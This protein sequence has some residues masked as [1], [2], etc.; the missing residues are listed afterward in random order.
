MTAF[1]QQEST[2]CQL[3]HKEHTEN[4][5]YDEADPES[6]CAYISSCPDCALEQEKSTEP[7]KTAVDFSDY[8][9][10][11]MPIIFQS[12][13]DIDLHD[14]FVGCGVDESITFTCSPE[15]VSFSDYSDGDLFNITLTATGDYEGSFDLEGEV[16]L[17]NSKINLNYP[18]SL[19]VT[20]VDD[21]T[22]ARLAGKTFSIVGTGASHSNTSG[23]YTTDDGDFNQDHLGQIHLLGP[24]N[25]V[26]SAELVFTFAGD[27][28]YE[29]KTVTISR[30]SDDWNSDTQEET[31]RLIPKRVVTVKLTNK[32]GQSIT[33]AAVK[34]GSTLLTDRGNGEYYAKCTNTTHTLQVSA[35]GYTGVTETFELNSDIT[36]EYTL[37]CNPLVVKD[38]NTALTSESVLSIP[39]TESKTL[40]T[41]VPLDNNAALT[42]SVTNG[43]ADGLG[44][45]VNGNNITITAKAL[46]EYKV[47]VT[48]THGSDTESITFGVNVP[49]KQVDYPYTPILDPESVTY[50]VDK[51]SQVIRFNGA[52]KDIIHNVTITASYA[53]GDVINTQT[54]NNISGSTVTMQLSDT[55]V[56]GEVTYSFE[57]FSDSLEYVS[58][59]K[60]GTISRTYML[61]VPDVTISLDKKTYEYDGTN[62]KPKVANLDTN[63]YSLEYGYCYD[64]NNFPNSY[65][66]ATDF[67]KPTEFAKVS[68]YK[69]KYYAVRAV[70]NE[71]NYYSSGFQP[72]GIAYYTVTKRNITLTADDQTIDFYETLDQ[73]KVTIGGSGLASGETLTYTLTPQPDPTSNGGTIAIDYDNIKIKRGNKDVT[74]YYNIT[75]QPGKY[76]VNKIDAQAI[77]VAVPE[78]TYN[79][80]AQTPDIAVKFSYDRIIPKSYYEV[81]CTDNTNAGTANYTITSGLW[82]GEITGTF[83]INPKPLVVSAKD[84]SKVYGAP[85]ENENLLYVY[86]TNEL[87]GSDTLNGIKVSR[88]PGEDAGEYTI[89]VSQE[90][91]SNPNYDITFKT[92]IF[93][94]EPKPITLVA[95]D[96]EKT[97]GEADCELT[98]KLNEGS[99]LEFNDTLS[100]ILIKRGTGEDVGE[101]TITID[102]AAG[103]NKNYNISFIYGKF[104]IKPK[105]LT[106]NVTVKDKQYDGLA[107]AEFEAELVGV[108]DSDAG[109][110]MLDRSQ[111]T[112]AFDSVLA[113]DGI[114]VALTG[115]FDYTCTGTKKEN[116]FITQPTGFTANIYNTYDAG[117][118]TVSSADWT[119]QDVVITANSD[120][121]LSLGY[122][123]SSVW[124]ETLTYSSEA[125]SPDGNEFTFYVRNGST[126]AISLPEKVM[127]KI[128]KTPAEGNIEIT[129]VKGWQELV[130][131]ITFGLFFKDAKVISINA[132]DALS[133]IRSIEYLESAQALTLDDLSDASFTPYPQGGVTV[134]L[135]DT[136]KFVYYAKITDNA[137]NI[138]FISTDGSVYDTT[139]PKIEGIENGKVYYVTQKAVVSDANIDKIT[140]NGTDTAS[141]IT[142]NGNT[143]CEYTITA[144]D[145]A[146]N[147]TTFKLTMK[148]ISTID[149]AIED[150][151]EG[152]V[153]SANKSDAEETKAQIEESLSS[154]EITEDEK[155]L[156]EN[157]LKEAEA[158]IE[159]IEETSAAAN[160]STI[161]DTD[162]LTE[163][164]ATVANYSD[165]LD[166]KA[167][168]EKV[169][170]DYSGNLT[171]SEITSLKADLS[172]INSALYSVGRVLDVM[173]L[174]GRLPDY[175]I[176]VEDYKGELAQRIDEAYHAYHSLNEHEQ[177]Q[178]DIYDLIKL[179]NLQDP[180][181]GSFVP[182][183]RFPTEYTGGDPVTK[184]GGSVSSG[185]SGTS[186]STSGGYRFTKGQNSRW[187]YNSRKG[188][189][190]TVNGDISKFSF[191]TVDGKVVDRN[192]YTA[193]SGSTVITLSNSFLK[194]L[195]LGNHS[196]KAYYVDGSTDTTAF[197][198]LESSV[199]P[200]TGDDSNA[201]IWGAAA[202]VGFIVLIAAI[203]GGK[204]SK[205]SK[206]R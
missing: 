133:G 143:D 200:F 96:K 111:V 157:E 6:V 57:F 183:T 196:I 179:V 30:T 121:L 162:N 189:T 2:I 158:L 186:A 42:A 167:A 90:N 153:T 184:P 195:S 79:A 78:V 188:L 182:G 8:L 181:A 1:A 49:K 48:Y 37:E 12:T 180:G 129:G 29:Y 41:D 75:V 63:K 176:S 155:A 65:Q 95:E 47:T 198:V 199:I 113:A 34:M 40:T 13:D 71:K 150:L 190:F 173:G 82:D 43:D 203:K 122:S 26:Y 147:M 61:S 44:I 46:G 55:P 172:R 25:Y 84:A 31:I 154:S 54:F 10:S 116:Y 165:L 18:G 117:E 73:S 32:H 24:N 125:A 91:G 141:P 68:N 206:R 136:K 53:N 70:G 101:Y 131:S 134:P 130:S 104:T 59:D 201:L 108:I 202:L 85:V 22:N 66:P 93:T 110:V 89:T 170:K 187:Y 36:K 7:A 137:G 177:S 100:N 185:N 126:K 107:D 175:A 67:T 142:L 120:Y 58:G 144:V 23:N 15:K 135:E 178:I 94:I 16:R 102:Q 86:D 76:T 160:S 156:L 166:A 112:A 81:A 103:E 127:M 128:D 69:V 163:N 159:K 19:I 38:G 52:D 152:N 204:K 33:G 132:T 205:K 80:S 114:A 168:I 74:K 115:D 5:G 87:E 118:Y 97:Y 151:T 3:H 197:T 17:V 109:K 161:T 194:T 106:V 50:A 123:D 174:I 39:G 193:A 20:V 99:S 88:A 28:D 60:P 148:P 164:N 72:A 51:T 105:E 145:K 140:L 14:Y 45:S 146:G 27:A 98:Y 139:L 171:A 169:L 35:N 119:N 64:F 56:Q 21:T 138:T 83:K 149:D 11:T 192:N 191:I 9:D 92:G 77:T 4:C 62:I 124:S